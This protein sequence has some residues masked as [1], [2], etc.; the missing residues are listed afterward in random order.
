MSC[1]ERFSNEL[2]LFSDWIRVPE[3][4]I[5]NA[6]QVSQKI[7]AWI[8]Q[9]SKFR[10]DR[11]RHGGSFAKGT[12]TFLKL[13]VDLVCYVQLE[14]T[15]ETTSD[16]FDFLQEVRDDWKQVLMHNTN[17][18]ESD[19]SKGKF[20]VKFELDGFQFDLCPAINFSRDLYEPIYINVR[21]KDCNEFVKYND[22]ASNRRSNY[23]KEFDILDNTSAISY[24]SKKEIIMNCLLTQIRPSPQRLVTKNFMPRLSQVLG[25]SQ[26]EAAVAFVNEQSDYVKKLIRITKFWQQSVAYCG[27]KS[28]RSFLF[29]CLAVR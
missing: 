21:S 15:F 23:G 7:Y 8:Q 3:G 2:E 12:S 28:G 13:D 19:L 29:E 9:Q 22:P 26:S 6:R 10:I 20:A 5:H 14:E 4:D 24:S 11:L 27:F 1:K 17:L 16:V 18:S 25:P